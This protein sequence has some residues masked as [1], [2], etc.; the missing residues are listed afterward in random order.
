M[1]LTFNQIR[2]YYLGPGNILNEDA[3]SA[4]GKNKGWNKGDLHKL[5]IV[6]KA[7]SALAAIQLEAGADD[8]RIYYQGLCALFLH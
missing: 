7:D 2:V 5:G 3:Y 6:L 8:I 4:G 1:I